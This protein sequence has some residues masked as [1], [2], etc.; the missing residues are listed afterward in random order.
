M[1]AFFDLIAQTTRTHGEI[2]LFIEFPI[3]FDDEI[4]FLSFTGDECVNALERNDPR[5]IEFL[6]GAVSGTPVI[7][8]RGLPY[9]ASEA[10]RN[11][12][13]VFADEILGTPSFLTLKDVS[14]LLAHHEISDTDLNPILQCAISVLRILTANYGTSCRIVYWRHEA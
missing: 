4:R 13:V 8:P 9:D 5:T 14:K 6:T 3:D 1:N 2:E 10:S 11:A 7:A 12:I